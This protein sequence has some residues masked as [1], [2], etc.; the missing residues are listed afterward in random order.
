MN[1]TLNIQ[2]DSPEELRQAI[3][4]LAAFG[5]IVPAQAVAQTTAEKPSRTRTKPAEPVQSDPEPTKEDEVLETIEHDDTPVPTVVE[6]RA[7]AQEAGKTPDDKKAI[8][9]LLDKYESKSI[10]DVPEDKRAAFLAGLE[11]I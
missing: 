4:G 3:T 8:K 2:A 5:G 9:A 7:K 11:S 6:L 10:S 1:I